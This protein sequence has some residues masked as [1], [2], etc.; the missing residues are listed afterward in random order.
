[1]KRIEIVF[2]DEPGIALPGDADIILARDREADALGAPQHVASL[3]ALVS[4]SKPV[5]YRGGLETVH[6]AE[7]I[8][9]LGCEKVLVSDGF[10]KTERT[11]EHFVR[12]L[13]EACVPIA[14]TQEQFDI[15][16]AAS[17]NWI[18]CEFVPARN[19]PEINLIGDFENAWG[20]IY[21]P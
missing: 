1:V 4:G 6:T 5:W 18:C 2:L 7:L 19:Q 12:R 11:P 13:G 14:D 17:A 15:A 21:E 16:I 8:L 20:R 10:Y 9:G 3:L